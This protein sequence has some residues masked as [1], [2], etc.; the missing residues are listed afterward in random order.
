MS[1]PI[2]YHDYGSLGPRRAYRGDVHLDDALDYVAS[3]ALL[4]VRGNADLYPHGRD[5]RYSCTPTQQDNRGGGE[6]E[7][8]R[9]V[10]TYHAKRAYA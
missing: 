7:S 4:L 1:G 3:E 10:R 6:R 5:R 2:V 8:K 9:F